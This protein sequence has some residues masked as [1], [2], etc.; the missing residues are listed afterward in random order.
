MA[1][2]MDFDEYRVF[3]GSMPG[4]PVGDEI[5]CF[6]GGQ[7]TGLIRF[8]EDGTQVPR[9]SWRYAAGDTRAVVQLHFPIRRCSGVIETLCFEKPLWMGANND[10]GWGFLGT[11]EHEPVGEQEA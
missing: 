7:Y 4:A 3:I 5:Q 11:A 8:Y 6:K 2:L 9:H 1:E 10:T